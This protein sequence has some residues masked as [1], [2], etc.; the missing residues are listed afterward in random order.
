MAK[1]NFYIFDKTTFKRSL[2]GE[3]QSD[4]NM[5][6]TI[7]GT[8]DSLSILVWSYEDYEIEPYTICWHK[9][10]NTWWIV[11]H[12]KIERYQ[13]EQGFIYVHSLELLGAIEL[14]S[15]RD[16]TDCGFNDNTYTVRQFIERLFSLSNIEFPLLFDSG[17]NQNFLAQNVNFIKTFENYTLL[18]ALREFLDAYN[19]SAKII[20]DTTIVNN[21][22][23]LY[24]ARLKIIPKTGNKNLTQHYLDSFDD[25]RETKSM[26]KNSFGTCVISNAEN[27]ISSKEK[28]YPSSGTVK[29]SSKENTIKSSNAILRLPSKVFKANWIKMMYMTWFD[30]VSNL[31]ADYDVAFYPGNDKA[32]DNFLNKMYKHA[33]DHF[34]Q[35][36]ADALWVDMQ[37]NK[38]EIAKKLNDVS[39]VRFFDGNKLIPTFTNDSSTVRIEKGDDVPYLTKMGYATGKPR[40]KMIFTDKETRNMLPQTFQGVYWERGSDEIGGFDFIQYLGYDDPLD[41]K[42]FWLEDTEYQSN[43]R[44]LYQFTRGNDTIYIHARA[45]I[46][47]RKNRISFV[48]NYIPMSDIKIKVDNQRT[49][50]DIQLYNQNGKITDNFALSKLINSYSKE[51]SSDNIVRYKKYTNYNDIPQVGSMVITPNGEYVINNISLTFYQN[52]TSQTNNFN[53]YIDCE[54]NMSKAIS[55]KSLMVNPNTNIRDYGIPQNF[56]VRRKQL[57]RD[58]YELNYSQNDDN[59]N[60]VYLSSSNIFRFGHN[61][62]NLDQFI[63]IMKMKYNSAIGGDTDNNIDDS[64]E[65]YYQLETTNYYMN[66]MFYIM[67]DFKD[68]NIIGYGS[69]N[70]WSGFDV[71][72]IFNGLTD[73][74]NIPI[75]YVDDNGK[76]K[77]IFIKLAT[78]ENV[79]SIYDTYQEEEGGSSF[80]DSLYNYSVFIPQYIYDNVISSITFEEENYN[81]DALEVP[82]FEYVCQI[83]DSDDVLIGDNILTQ[84]DGNIVYFYSYIKGHNLTQENAT[85]TNRVR[86]TMSSPLGWK[87]NDGALLYM[88]TINDVKTLVLRIYGSQFLQLDDMSWYNQNEVDFEKGY[89]YAF[90]RHTYNLSTQEEIVDLLLIAKNVP[91]IAL[92]NNRVLWLVINHYKLK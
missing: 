74:I 8:K 66:K 47:V 77:G 31:H 6:L 44:I 79:T 19:M 55:T 45:D 21:N 62:N 75:S 17:I 33:Q 22:I 35:S 63:A 85:T 73:E 36:F 43:E 84:Y 32:V 49:K 86:E 52:E 72:R 25:A 57:Y 61:A 3:I 10:T 29:L 28:T 7:D 59:E 70:V 15:A 83:D 27:V 71:S 68:N 30:I 20:F 37:E 16:L 80:T 67:L 54:F 82:V 92:H 24:Y 11:S 40:A 64:D 18:S 42:N 60:D 1:D 58:Y 9:K 89:D 26:D 56:N 50:K 76:L 51:I 91:E 48:V 41:F 88:S 5:S 39:S 78:N 46:E 23:Q 53:Y 69:Q 12:D 81:K 14:L 4:F 34:S 90:F 65:W 87:V 38:E 2:L 13:N